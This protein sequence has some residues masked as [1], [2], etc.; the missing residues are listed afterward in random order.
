MTAAQ[1][2]SR[3][4]PRIRDLAYFCRLCHS[5]PPCSRQFAYRAAAQEPA[6]LVA[7]AQDRDHGDRGVDPGAGDAGQLVEPEQEGGRDGEGG[8]QSEEGGEADE[9]AD[10][11]TGG[12]MPGMAVKERME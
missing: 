11:E 9:D 4:V 5:S 12:D 3:E 10:R 7:Q 1:K 8:V 6:Q 2:P